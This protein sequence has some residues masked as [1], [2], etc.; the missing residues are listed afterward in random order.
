MIADFRRKLAIGDRQ[1]FGSELF[2]EYSILFLE[3][4]YD[5]ALI[6]IDPTGEERQQRL[7]G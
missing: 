6:A 4:L 7:K 1:A 2:S 3:V 5:I